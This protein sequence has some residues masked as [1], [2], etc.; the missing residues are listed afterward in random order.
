VIVGFGLP[1]GF[2]GSVQGLV[3]FSRRETLHG[4]KQ[5]AWGDVRLDEQV[6]MVG[7]DDVSVQVVVVE[8]VRS[9]ADSIDDDAGDGFTRKPRRPGTGRIQVAVHPD[10]GLAG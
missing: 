3:G 2:P 10:E 7:H 8:S 4:L 9:V 1:E 5:F 6:D